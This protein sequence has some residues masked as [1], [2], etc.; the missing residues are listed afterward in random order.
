MASVTDTSE[1]PAELRPCILC[2]LDAS[3]RA[4]E[5][6]HDAIAMCEEHGAELYVVWVLEPT[7]FRSPFP[8]ASG[9]VGAFGLPHVLRT[10][11][12]RARERGIPATS[13]V[14]IGDRE[15]VLRQE[16]R[17]TRAQSIFR[18]DGAK[19]DAASTAVEVVRCPH[20]GW[21]LDA[22]AVHLCPKV[23]LDETTSRELAELPD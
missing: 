17:A 18:I 6:L 20:C 1:F 4:D 23:H 13:A 9:A 2:E 16:A 15:V 21:R 22:R 11:I 19:R 12:E 8:G 3:K 7:L 14:R 5:L 10:A